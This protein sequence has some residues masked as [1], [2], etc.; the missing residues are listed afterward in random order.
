MGDLLEQRAIHWDDLSVGLGDVSPARTITEADL[1]A[2]SGLSGDYNPIHTDRELA[3]SLAPG[4]E[5]LVHGLLAQCI[6]SGLFTRGPLGA[7]LGAQVIAMLEVKTAFRRPV[8][9]GDTVHVRSSV[10]SLRETSKPDRGIAV[11][12]RALT[13]QDGETVQDI[14][15]TLLVRRR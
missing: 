12:E 8:R 4:G 7:G 15:T 14:E 10:G 11:L 13:N 2:Y 3:R 5:M 1:V 9:V 6:A